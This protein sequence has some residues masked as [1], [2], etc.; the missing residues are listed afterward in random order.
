MLLSL[1]LC[2]EMRSKLDLHTKSRDCGKHT[3]RK[4]AHAEVRKQYYAPV[5]E[6]FLRTFALLIT[7]FRLAL[8]HLGGCGSQAIRNFIEQIP[9]CFIE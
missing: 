2:C 5:I 3:T 9:R 8:S 1:L 4:L 6:Q 7:Q